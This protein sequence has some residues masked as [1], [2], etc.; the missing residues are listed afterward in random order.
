[1]NGKITPELV[2]AEA[3]LTRLEKAWAASLSLQD[4]KWRRKHYELIA[5]F[6]AEVREA[7]VLL[8][9]LAEDEV[10]ATNAYLAVQA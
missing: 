2:R 6:P 9:V 4:E 5:S 7:L 3:A 1:M 10:K 8:K